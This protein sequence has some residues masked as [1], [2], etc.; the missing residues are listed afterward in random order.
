MSDVPTKTRLCLAIVIVLAMSLLILHGA[1]QAC[2]TCKDGLAHDG[3][4]MAQ[5]YAMSI[6]FMMTMPFAIFTGL[7]IYFYL[8]VRRA[9]ATA[10]AGVAQPVALDDE[11]AFPADAM[12]DAVSCEEPVEV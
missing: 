5:G 6:L 9:R 11:A 8:L 3:S 2:P 7:G 10:S 12:D 1:A 4:N